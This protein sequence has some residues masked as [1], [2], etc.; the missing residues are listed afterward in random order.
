ML[1]VHVKKPVGKTYYINPVEESFILFVNDHPWAVADIRP[2]NRPAQQPLEANL[3]K[4]SPVLY[5][6]P[7]LPDGAEVVLERTNYN[8]RTK[9]LERLR[10]ATLVVDTSRLSA[11]Q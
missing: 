8:L 6:P 5:F 9:T 4:H 11:A 3:S 7:D 1:M 10:S 2:P